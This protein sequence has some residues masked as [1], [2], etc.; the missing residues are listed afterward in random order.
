MALDL[1]NLGIAFSGEILNG[2]FFKK[3]FLKFFDSNVFVPVMYF[4][5]TE[6]AND[7]LPS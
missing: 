3:K 6:Y 2:I 7:Q 1:T 4:V 5:S